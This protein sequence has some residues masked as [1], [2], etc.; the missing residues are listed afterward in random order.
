M[1]CC[2][3]RSADRGPAVPKLFD[4]N[5]CRR[6]VARHQ[7]HD[8]KW[9]RHWNANWLQDF[10]FRKC[11]KNRCYP[12]I[13]WLPEGKVLCLPT[14]AA[15]FLLIDVGF[16]PWLPLINVK[17]TR[18]NHPQVSTIPELG[19][20]HYCGSPP[21]P[22][23]SSDFTRIYLVQGFSVASN[24]LSAEPWRGRWQVGKRFQTA[25]EAS[26]TRSIIGASG[27]FWFAPAKIL[28]QV[29][30]WFVVSQKM[31]FL[32]DKKT[33]VRPSRLNTAPVSSW[34]RVG[35]IYLASPCF[36]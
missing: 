9:F 23:C 1:W 3:V 8:D 2:S 26:A 14:S 12:Q 32:P 35:S 24:A 5:P 21:Y 27:R 4:S 28:V 17:P 10:E 13:C 31:S 29:I 19:M 7:S 6:E 25:A 36:V 30:V 20:V 11:F 16:G 18:V 33:H 15:S 34:F 22:R